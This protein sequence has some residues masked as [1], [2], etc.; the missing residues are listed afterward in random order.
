MLADSTPPSGTILVAEDEPGLR[1][2]YRIWLGNKWNVRLASDGEEAIKKFDSD[3]SAVLLDKRMPHVDGTDVATE[4]RAQSPC[5]IAMISADVPTTDILSGPL[6]AYLCKPVTSETVSIAVDRLLALRTFNS[7]VREYFALSMKLQAIEQECGPLPHE[8]DPTYQE[9]KDRVASLSA[10][11]SELIDDAD[12]PSPEIS[13]LL[14]E[15][16]R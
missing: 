6:D 4:I 5:P 9:A 16:T 7:C 1:E 12:D 14:H 15:F 2:L 11:V 10:H 13:A 3:I 8:N